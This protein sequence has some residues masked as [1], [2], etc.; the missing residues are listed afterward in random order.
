MVDFAQ[1]LLPEQEDLSLRL[2]AMT[3]VHEATHGYLHARFIPYTKRTRSRVERI[4]EN[5][6]NHFVKQLGDE[7]S[8]LHC[9]FL[10]DDYQRYWKASRLERFKKDW[11]R[12]RR[13]F[14]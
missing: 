5:E 3:L 11:E 6:E 13:E 10:E 14:F 7:W 1:L 2:Y 12:F 4:C 9:T 8:H